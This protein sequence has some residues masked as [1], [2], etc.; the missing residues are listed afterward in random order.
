[1]K[2]Y[3]IFVQKVQEDVCT[4]AFRCSKI[5]DDPTMTVTY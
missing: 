2:H 3:D 5:V 4:R 1:L